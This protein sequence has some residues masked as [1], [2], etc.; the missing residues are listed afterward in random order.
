MGLKCLVYLF[1][2]ICVKS[3]LNRYHTL[4]WLSTAGGLSMTLIWDLV[5]MVMMVMMM[6]MLLGPWQ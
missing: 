6:V 1:T 4:K 5:A 3:L 2:I